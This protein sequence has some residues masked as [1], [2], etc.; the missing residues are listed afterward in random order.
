MTPERQLKFWRALV[1]VF[2]VLLV[3]HSW[4]W[5]VIYRHQRAAL[6]DAAINLERCMTEKPQPCKPAVT[7]WILD[8]PPPPDEAGKVMRCEALNCKWVR[9]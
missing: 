6:R 1:G 8:V 7:S 9:P 5:Y 4:A 2:L 3:M